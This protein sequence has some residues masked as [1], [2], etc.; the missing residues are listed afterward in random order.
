MLF[1]YNGIRAGMVPDGQGIVEPHAT[2][3]M[4][5]AMPSKL[6]SEQFEVKMQ[7][8][9]K[10][11]YKDIEAIVGKALASLR[12]DVSLLW[13]EFKAEEEIEIN[14]QIKSAATIL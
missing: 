3:L 1:H 8:I 2:K 13:E 9:T 7:E 6:F 11:L 12:Y 4:N 14:D 5:S 10:K